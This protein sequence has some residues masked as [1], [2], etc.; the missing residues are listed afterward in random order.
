[1]DR[2]V[3][4]IVA[5]YNAEKFVRKCMDSLLEQTYPITEIIVVYDESPD[6]TLGILRQYGD[7]IKL[8][9]QSKTNPATARNVG[10]SHAEG[11][12]IA[13]CD[14]DDF[15]APEKIEREVE[16]LERNPD[17]GMVYTDVIRIDPSG[18][19]IDRVECPE[20]SRKEWLLFQF[21][22]FSSILVRKELLELL[23]EEDGYYFDGKVPAFDDFDFLIRLSKISEFKRLPEFLT[24]YTVHLESLS[25]DQQR[26]SII[27]SQIEWK[28][29]LL[30]NW[31][32]SIF[33]RI[34][35]NYLIN[36]SPILNKTYE[37]GKRLVAR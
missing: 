10:V 29:K 23:R 37:F 4:V 1:M 11:E 26:M 36:K 7:R 14:I 2:Q 13:F 30:R 6:N 5:V 31:V 18:N 12:Y 35:K 34:P 32:M 16:I 3:S 25:A 24:Y 33:L 9:G 27:R 19:E 20:W 8:I 28:H 21:I 17:T 22:T 15:F